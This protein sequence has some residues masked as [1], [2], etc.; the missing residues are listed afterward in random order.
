MTAKDD[1]GIVTEGDVGPECCDIPRTKFSHSFL[2]VTLFHVF[3]MQHS[4]KAENVAS[5]RK[6]FLGCPSSSLSQK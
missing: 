1:D 2:G 6:F 5:G 3:S 4:F